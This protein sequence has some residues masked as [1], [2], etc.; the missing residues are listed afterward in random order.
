MNP[1]CTIMSNDDP[2]LPVL[3][4]LNQPMLL[5]TACV[6]KSLV[7]WLLA[8]PGLGLVSLRFA[9]RLLGKARQGK[10]RH[11]PT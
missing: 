10:A 9:H 11:T 5:R 2:I 6:P 7:L 4:T 1:I 8:R 3:V